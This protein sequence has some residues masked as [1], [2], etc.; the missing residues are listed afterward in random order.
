MSKIPAA[1]AHASAK[2]NRIENDEI[3]PGKYVKRSVLVLQWIPSS[4][5][6]KETVPLPRGMTQIIVPG[7]GTL[8]GETWSPKRAKAVAVV[9]F[10]GGLN[11]TV[12]K[13]RSLWLAE[14][15]EKSRSSGGPAPGWHPVTPSP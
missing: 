1:V 15:G 11:E 13:E 14:R 10:A 3:V 8:H 2:R 4:E 7:A 12:T 6:C 5:I 9:T